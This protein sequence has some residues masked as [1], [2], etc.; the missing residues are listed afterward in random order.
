MA[1]NSLNYGLRIVRNVFIF[2]IRSSR[3]G[4]IKIQK[5]SRTHVPWAL[6][7]SIRTCQ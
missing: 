1:I 7:H 3:T 4:V 2:D 6:V 5:P